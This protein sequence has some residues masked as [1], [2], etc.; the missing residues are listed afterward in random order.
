MTMA[1]LGAVACE[2][3]TKPPPP[4][5]FVVVGPGVV[6]MDPGATQQFGVVLTDVNGR[7]LEGRR[8]TWSVQDPN[9]ASVSATGVVTARANLGTTERLTLVIADV[10]GKRGQATMVVRP[11]RAAIIR[12]TSTPPVLTDGQSTTLAATVLDSANNV[13]VGRQVMWS[14]RDVATAVV[15][16]AG[17]VS[18]IAFLSGANRSAVIVASIGAAQDSVA[19]TVAPSALQQITIFP[20]EPYVQ[21]GWAK[22]LRVDGRTAGGAA[23][24]GI[25]PTFT[26][27]NPAVATVNSAGRLSTL[28]SASGTTQVIASF[29]DFADTVTVTVDNCGAAPA[30]TFPLDI[31]FYGANPPTPSVAA[32]FTCAANRIRAI[33][34]EPVG[35]TA[36]NNTDISGCIGQAATLNESSAGLI[37]Y[38]RVD[39]IDGPGQVLG[40]AGPCFVRTTSRLPVLGVMRFDN[41][42]LANL[43]A[44][45]RLLAVILHEMLHVIGIGTSWRDGLRVPQL[46]TG[47]VPNPGF[48][49]PRAIASCVNDLGAG[50]LCLDRVP[51]E[52]CVAGVPASCGPG[53]RLGHWREFN[54]RTELMTG[55]V[56]AAGVQNPFSRMTIQALA[57]LGYVVDPDQ[58]NDYVL[59]TT[60]MMESRAA[61]RGGELEMPPPQM[62]THEI[63][64][65]GR[66]NPLRPR[67]R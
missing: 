8:V 59:P 10:E 55:Y 27:S 60:L 2:A 63:D 17:V 51:I 58:S 9:V 48:T 50:V 40:S 30:G 33:I 54:F 26:S 6:T 46:W 52:D 25:T 11:S 22:T 47:D 7:R 38:A 62:P 61:G 53:T 56:S 31:R 23:V 45:G 19:V 32:A 42:D 24:A 1:A 20:Q 57:D 37:I 43:E 64:S 16:T 41:A 34:R 5:E 4:V 65:R 21:A 12:I 18:P 28:A 15:S 44:D 29:G 35:L 39:S 36:F 14:S 66:L 13:L 67:L 3:P 49:G